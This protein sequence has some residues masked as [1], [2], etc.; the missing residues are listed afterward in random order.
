MKAQ[1]RRGLRLVVYAGLLRRDW[2]KMEKLIIDRIE[3]N[4][5]VCEREDKTMTDIKL[6]DMPE[7]VVEGDVI[8]FDGSVYRLEKEE[9]AD[10][11]HLI[12]EKMDNLFVD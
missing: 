3:G 10:R 12:Q 9:T 2:N 5:A 4:V 8:S 11:R 6:A 1:K 7:G